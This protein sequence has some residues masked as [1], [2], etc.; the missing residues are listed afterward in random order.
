MHILNK[1]AFN[2]MKDGVVIINTAR[3]GL[4]NEADLEEALK[5]GKV[6]KYVTDVPTNGTIKLPNVV[7]FP[8]LG[9]CTEEAE[10]NCAVMAVKEVRDYLE[11]GNINNSVNFP[12]V[13]LGK[14]KGTRITILF[15]NEENIN[16]KLTA[17]VCGA[18][19]VCE[20]GVKTQGDYG[21]AIYEVGEGD[22]EKAI[23]AVEAISAVIRTRVI[24]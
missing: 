1:A 2:E 24:G 10:D 14:R 4:V 12:R 23:R 7:A 11:N 17:A 9:A 6:K 16:G 20:I 5:S 18:L 8:H 19:S 22:T 3:P 15:K 13:S 21:Y